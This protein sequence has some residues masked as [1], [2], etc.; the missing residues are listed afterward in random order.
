MRLLSV[1][2]PPPPLVQDLGFAQCSGGLSVQQF[3]PELAVEAFIETVFPGAPG[4]DVEGFDLDFRILCQTNPSIAQ[5]ADNLFRGLSAAFSL[6]LL[7]RF[8]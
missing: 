8:E 7:L 6:L 3:I 2:V 1:V 4:C 5:L